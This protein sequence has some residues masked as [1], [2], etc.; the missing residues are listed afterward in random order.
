VKKSAVFLFVGALLALPASVSSASTAAKPA[1]PPQRPGLIAAKDLGPSHGGPSRA[2]LGWIPLHAHEL[3]EAKARANA[4]A[5]KPARPR[6]GG[7][8]APVVS[9]YANVSPSFDGT[10]MSG[11]TPPDTTG[12]MGPDRYIETVNT[13]Y[14]IY[15]RSGSLLNGGSLSALTGISGG[16]F[17]YNLSDPQMMWDAKTQRFYYSAVYY[18]FFFFDTG[19]AVGFSK[20]A[21][22]A[23]ASDFCQYAIQFGGELPDYPKLG[24]S[25]DFLLFGYNKFGDRKSVV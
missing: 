10:F 21:T 13:R 5:S 16:L 18:D 22:P 1:P 24:D 2:P 17:G 6:P 12:A 3:A 15:S 20:T 7:G 23:S 9:T 8:G 4:Q 14:A 25:S 19:L 11:G